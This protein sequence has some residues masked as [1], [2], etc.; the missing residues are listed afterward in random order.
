MQTLPAN[1][2]GRTSQKLYSM[3]AVHTKGMEMLPKMLGL[4]EA[5]LM[6]EPTLEPATVPGVAPTLR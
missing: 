6:T 4:P 5:S 1:E 2:A 3:P